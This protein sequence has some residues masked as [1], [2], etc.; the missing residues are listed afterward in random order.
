MDVY[1][2]DTAFI[3][4]SI[5]VYCLTAQFK[6]EVILNTYDKHNPAKLVDI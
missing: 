4:I 5:S 3:D 6:L 1:Y 2:L